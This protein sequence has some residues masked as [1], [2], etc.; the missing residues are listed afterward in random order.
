MYLGS[1]MICA[2]VGVEE[3]MVAAELGSTYEQY[4]STRSRMLPGSL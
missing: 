2:R 1:T 4:A 3:R